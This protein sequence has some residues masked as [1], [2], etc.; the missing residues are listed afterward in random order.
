[1]AATP[2][3]DA[4]PPPTSTMESEGI[5]SSVAFFYSS[6]VL[7]LVV[8]L[9]VIHVVFIRYIQP[10]IMAYFLNRMRTV[11]NKAMD[12][13]KQELLKDLESLRP[14]KSTESEK[15]SVEEPA[16]NGQTTPGITVLEIGVGAGANF[17]YYP[18]GTEVVGIEPNPSFAGYLGKNAAE[19]YPRVRLQRT[20]VAYAEDLRGHVDD[21]SVDAV[22]STLVLC[23]V[24]DV[25]AVI[26][27][28]KR[29]LKPGGKFYFLEHVCAEPGTWVRTIQWL[30]HPVWFYFGDGCQLMQTPWVN[31]DQAGFSKVLYKKFLA[32]PKLIRLI[33]P[34]VMGFATK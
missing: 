8:V 17:K 4:G 31:V 11:Y 22:V 13:F 2:G 29:V 6:R 25:D 19:Y 28:A 12:S 7:L 23:S 34:H 14:E 26:K 3:N 15:E 32:H 30:I 33:R 9:W 20:V 10:P 21:S 18:E 24:K 16:A 1:M 27:E 5:F